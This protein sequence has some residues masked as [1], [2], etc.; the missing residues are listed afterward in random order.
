M[1]NTET[2]TIFFAGLMVCLVVPKFLDMDAVSLE[3][4]GTQTVQQYL[5]EACRS[6][7]SVADQNEG[8]VFYNSS[9]RSNVINEFYD[10]MNK[11]LGKDIAAP[12]MIRYRV[13]CVLMVDKDGFYVNYSE[14]YNDTT[15][16]KTASQVIT[17][18]N[19]W[20]NS[21]GIYTV[22]FSLTDCI[23]VTNSNSDNTL[24]GTYTDI[25]NQ[26]G[27]PNVLSFMESKSEFEAE[28]NR[29]IIEKVEGQT[30][31]YINVHNNYYD[32][33][34]VNYNFTM[35][36]NI[37]DLSARMMKN[38]CVIAFYQGQQGNTS[39]NYVNIWAL[40]AAENTNALTYY[41]YRD[42]DGALYYHNANCSDILSKGTYCFTGTADECAKMDAFPCPDC[43][44]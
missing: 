10:I 27:K 2:F 29:I 36:Q 7:M 8:D 4:D 14:N 20:S 31:Y 25:Y 21:Y 30:E 35:P 15:G 44:R 28:K 19:T 9:T 17:P 24:N 3:T 18:L 42:A 12:E 33:Y 37:N 22:K 39:S 41:V 11:N 34:D 32:K 1:F 43:I 26:L 13:P 38:P 16:A 40:S 23:Q 5:S 6:A